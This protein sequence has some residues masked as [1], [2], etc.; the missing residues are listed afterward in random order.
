M[1][2]KLSEL[3]VKMIDN[4]NGEDVLSL[5]SNGSTSIQ[6]FSSREEERFESIEFSCAMKKLDDL[7]IPRIDELN[8]EFSIVGRIMWLYRQ[9]NI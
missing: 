9:S 2:N 5:Y 6:T 8:K 4:W 7:M 1:N 3:Q